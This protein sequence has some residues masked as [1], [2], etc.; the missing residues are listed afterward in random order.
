MTESMKPPERGTDVAAFISELGGGVD[1][2]IMSLMLSNIASAVDNTEKQGSINIKIDL[3]KTGDGGNVS[4]KMK[5]TYVKPTKKGRT[6]EER[7]SE[8]PMYVGTGGRLSIF[9]ETQSDMFGKH[10]QAQI[11]ANAQD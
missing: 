11:R 5:S 1:E 6:V 3:K 10:K 2:E 4:V 8:T 7:T 9:P